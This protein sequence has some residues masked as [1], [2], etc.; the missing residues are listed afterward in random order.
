MGIISGKFQTNIPE[1]SPPQ[2]PTNLLDGNSGNIIFDEGESLV[3]SNPNMPD[4]LSGATVVGFRYILSWTCTQ[5][6]DFQTQVLDLNNDG[7][8]IAGSIQEKSVDA[9]GQSIIIGGPTNTLGLTFSSGDVSQFAIKI[10]VPTQS[11]LNSSVTLNASP[12]LNPSIYYSINN[13]VYNAGGKFSI[14]GGKVSI[15]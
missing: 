10:T 4:I 2:N 13:K 1:P 7:A 5:D 8:T 15:T 14:G 3:Y 9:P 12:G 11:P 6:F